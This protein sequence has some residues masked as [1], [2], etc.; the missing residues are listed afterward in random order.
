MQEKPF[1]VFK[2]ISERKKRKKSCSEIFLGPKKGKSYVPKNFWMRK[3]AFF[4]SKKNS[5]PEKR[6]K[7]HPKKFLGPKKAKN[8]V[9][10]RVYESDFL[11][12]LHS[13]TR[14]GR[15]FFPFS[16]FI[17]ACRNPAS[18]CCKPHGINGVYVKVSVPIPMK[19]PKVGPSDGAL[20]QRPWRRPLL[21][22][23]D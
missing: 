19:L 12:F 23:L 4:V 13:Y 20:G 17:Y 15:R 3:K 6:K 22:I 9:L 8:R 16:A 14:V 7:S 2:K 5:E 11:L 1:F 10:K 18:A 21:S